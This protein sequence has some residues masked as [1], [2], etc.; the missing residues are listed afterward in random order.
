MLVSSHPLKTCTFPDWRLFLCS[1][2]TGITNKFSLTSP[3]LSATLAEHT[4]PIERSPCRTV[5]SPFLLP[6]WIMSYP[7]F[8][9][10]R[11]RVFSRADL[12]KPRPYKVL[13]LSHIHSLTHSLTLSRRISFTR[14]R[15]SSPHP[16]RLLR[17]LRSPP[18]RGSSA[19]KRARWT[20][21]VKT[22]STTSSESSTSSWSSGGA[23]RDRESTGG[24]SAVGKMKLGP[25][26]CLISRRRDEGLCERRSET[27]S[28]FNT[29]PTLLFFILRIRKR[30]LFAFRWWLGWNAQ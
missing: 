18:R 10:C 16:P 4:P 13:F 30:C 20:T 23:W 9:Q 26:L 17:L 25:S 11:R 19:G 7:Y 5:L 29:I 6:V 28:T 1:M 15:W 8:G 21:W 27:E 14:T 24:G 12:E 22:H 2:N 3:W